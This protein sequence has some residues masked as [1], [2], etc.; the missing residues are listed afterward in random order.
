MHKNSFI[1]LFGTALMCCG[2]QLLWSQ[3]NV[4]GTVTDS[5]SGEALF[6]TVV[7]VTGTSLGAIA[8]V[9]GKY[10]LDIS[11]ENFA[12]DSLVFSYIGYERIAVAIALRNI[13]NVAL[14]PLPTELGDVVITAIGV[15]R[16]KKNSVM[17]LQM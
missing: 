12:D 8:D 9:D 4:S 13:I 15:I 1:Q 7:R 2:T 3:Q 17:Q 5:L 16:E 11:D 14:V 6:G 10:S